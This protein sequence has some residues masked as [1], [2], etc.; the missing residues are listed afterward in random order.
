MKMRR[1]KEIIFWA[2]TNFF[3]AE[4]TMSRNHIPIPK[5]K[6][7]SHFFRTTVNRLA[8]PTTRTR[9]V[10]SNCRE[11]CRIGKNFT[12]SSSVKSKI[13]SDGRVAVSRR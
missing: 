5:R 3:L 12:S 7:L 11:C 8:T 10:N 4:Q 6:K 13:R 2:N 9:W 1:K